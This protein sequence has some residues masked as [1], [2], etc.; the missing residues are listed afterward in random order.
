MHQLRTQADLQRAIADTRTLVRM[1]AHLDGAVQSGRWFPEDDVLLV[2]AQLA[3]TFLKAQAE[4]AVADAQA[5][6]VRE[7]TQ[8]VVAAA[9]RA[10]EL[11]H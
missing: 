8:R 11:R 10:R 9:Q 3:H 5:Q 2:R 7:S 1:G 4:A 6:R